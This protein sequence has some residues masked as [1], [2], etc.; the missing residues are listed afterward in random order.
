LLFVLVPGLVSSVATVAA[1]ETGCVA[2]KNVPVTATEPVI[3]VE[4]S[5][6]GTAD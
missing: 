5:V 1:I 6:T 4:V 3:V 2:W